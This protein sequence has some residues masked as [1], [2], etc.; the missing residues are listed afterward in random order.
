MTNVGAMEEVIAHNAIYILQGIAASLVERSTLAHD[1]EYTTAVGHNLALRRLGTHMV[2]R[3]LDLIQ[4]T[5]LY[6]LG[7]VT[8][9]TL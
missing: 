9:I 4:T 2:Y 8:R 6:P 1:K 7:I 5:D 3:T